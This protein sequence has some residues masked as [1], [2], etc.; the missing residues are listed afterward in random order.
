MYN[1][2]IRIKEVP[3]G[4]PQTTLNKTE[5]SLHPHLRVSL[6]VKLYANL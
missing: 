5:M 3:L 4:L 1:A 2:A 6:L